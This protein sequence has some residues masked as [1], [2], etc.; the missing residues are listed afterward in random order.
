MDRSRPP[1][2]EG[3]FFRRLV[4]SPEFTEF[5]LILKRLTGLS[6]ALNTP[7]VGT[8]RIGVSGDMGNPLCQIIRNTPEGARRC[9]GC[10]RR[11]HALAGRDG[12][13]K[14]YTCHA[15][16]LDFAIPIMI[17]GEHVA[18]ISSGQVLPEK[19]TPRARA[20]TLRRLGWLGVPLSRL[21]AAYKGAPWLPRDRLTEVMNL[22]ELFSRQMISS[23]WRIRELEASQQR[24]EIRA[25]QAL[26][27]KR[28]TDPELALEEAATA[29][30][31]SVAH[32]SNLFHKRTGVTFTHYVQTRRIEEAKRL[33]AET[34]RSIT[35]I[36]Y[37]CGFNSLTHFNRVFRR[38]TGGS[39]TDYRQQRSR[40]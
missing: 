22:L 2:T 40:T 15:G 26:V 33:L 24:P 17:Q 13:S 8:T 12:H 27:E 10:D 19:P 32:F 38:G 14:L 18:T 36:C 9:E 5:A 4:A 30:G 11:H 35:D 21:R 25:A 34:D 20:Q 7:D 1:S 16:F 23:A 39:P 3:L 6:M 31:L 29:V 37:A 28:F